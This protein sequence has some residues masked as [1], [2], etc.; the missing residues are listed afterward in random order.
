MHAAVS[1]AIL[2]SSTLHSIVSRMAAVQATVLN[3]G[4]A[5]RRQHPVLTMQEQLLLYR[6]NRDPW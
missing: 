6:D 5:G 1:D 4:E 3:P 2:E